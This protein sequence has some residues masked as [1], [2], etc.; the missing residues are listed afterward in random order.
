[1]FLHETDRVLIIHEGVRSGI[2]QIPGGRIVEKTFNGNIQ[3]L[4]MSHNDNVATLLVDV[5][6]G[7]QV[8]YECKQ[9]LLFIEALTDIP[10]GHKMAIQPIAKG[11]KVLKYGE[12]IGVAS[13]DITIGEYIHVHNIEGVRGRGDYKDE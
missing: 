4:V 1:M 7:G 10:F 6:K 12:C 8:T 5:K 13:A 11:G 2:R 9:E 3:G